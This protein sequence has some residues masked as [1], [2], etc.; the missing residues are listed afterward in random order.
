MAR[1]LVARSSWASITVRFRE[2]LGRRGGGSTSCRCRRTS[3]PRRRRC[4]QPRFNLGT[5]DSTSHHPTLGWPRRA[6]VDQAVQATEASLA[7]H[8]LDRT[9]RDDLGTISAQCCPNW[10]SPSPT[11]ASAVST[12]ATISSWST[13]PGHGDHHVR[14]PVPAVVERP[15]LR[16]SIA[17]TVS[18]GRALPNRADGPETLGDADDVGRRIGAP[19]ELLENHP[20]FGVK[21]GL[22]ELRIDEN[23]E[24]GVQ[25]EVEFPGRNPSERCTL[26]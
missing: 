18:A 15:N 1:P 26:T 5:G 6:H 7:R 22:G 4:S 20:T 17:C 21:F 25:T 24:Q 9:R 12:R 2:M 19:G 14:P 23:V 16:R 13:G 10:R 3:R 8:L 11:T